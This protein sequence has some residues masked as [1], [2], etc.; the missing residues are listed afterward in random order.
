[1]RILFTKHPLPLLFLL[2]LPPMQLQG[3]FS[4]FYLL[5]NFTKEEFYNYL[6]EIYG[7]GPTRPP[8]KRKI[9]KI[10]LVE[11]DWRPLRDPEY[12]TGEMKYKNVHYKMKCV[13]YH[14]FLQT[15]YELLQQTCYNTAVL[16]RGGTNT[17]KMSSKAVEGVFCKLTQ[18]TRMPDCDYES[19]YMHGYVVITCRWNNETQ[20]FIPHTINNIVPH[21]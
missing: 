9:E 4:N 18:G 15:S 2:L 13:N 20:E 12:C 3:T 17:C 5:P 10:V 8:S 6:Y 21:T 16:C 1:M 11:E 19:T 14:Y 7:T